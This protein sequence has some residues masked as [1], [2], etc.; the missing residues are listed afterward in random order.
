M[1]RVS[2]S[3]AASVHGPAQPQGIEPPLPEPGDNEGEGDGKADVAGV[4]QR[5]VQ[6]EAGVLQQRVEVGAVKGGGQGAAEGVG[7]EADEGDEA[8][9]DV[10]E[11]GEDFRAQVVWQRFAADGECGA[12]EAEDFYPKEQRAFVPAPGGGEAVVPRQQA[13]AV[14]GDV[15]HREVVREEAVGEDGKAEGEQRALRFRGADGDGAGDAAVGAEGRQDGLQEGYRTREPEGI[16][17]GFDDHRAT[18]QT[19]AALAERFIPAPTPRFP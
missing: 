16:V 12:P 4:E 14:G 10:A 15:A 8:E 13:V 3:Q 11:D 6:D 1:P 5:R 19:V 7:G 17:A 18:L 9:A 2:A